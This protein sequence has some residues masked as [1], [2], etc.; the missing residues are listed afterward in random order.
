MLCQIV[1]PPEIV[2]IEKPSD[3]TTIIA[4][5]AALEETR[6][7]LASSERSLEELRAEHEASLETASIKAAAHADTIDLLAG[8]TARVDTIQNDLAAQR[9]STADAEVSCPT[10]LPYSATGIT[11]SNWDSHSAI[12]IPTQPLG[13]ALSHWDPHSA[14]GI[15][16]QPLGSPLSHWDPHSAIGIP[17]RPL[18]SPLSRMGPP[19]A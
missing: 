8:A 10:R 6:I 18:E 2:Y 9:S 3:D 14:F 17:T 5:E 12:G 1:K 4:L 16:T 15:P 7:S 13:S 19:V 11:L